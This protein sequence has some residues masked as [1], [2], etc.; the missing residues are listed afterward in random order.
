MQPQLYIYIYIYIKSRE[1]RG[2]ILLEKKRDLMQIIK[3][4]Q[5][6]L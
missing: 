6:L 2:S 5:E 4:G 1:Q 3:G